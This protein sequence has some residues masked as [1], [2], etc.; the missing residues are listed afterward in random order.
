MITVGVDGCPAGWFAVRQSRETLSATLY[1]AFSSLCEDNLDATILVDIPM[2]LLDNQ[3][4]NVEPAARKLLG[5]RRSS[6]FPVPCRDAVYASSYR[7]ACLINL[8]QLGKKISMQAWNI[9]PKIREADAVRRRH[10]VEVYE[11]HP[12][13]DFAL[14]G[15]TPMMNGKKTPEGIN[16]RLALLE[17]ILPGAP[18]LFHESVARYPRSR[19]ARDDIVDAMAL[20][21]TAA[22]CNSGLVNSGLVEVAQHDRFGLAVQLII[23]CDG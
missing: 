23:P 7:E 11:S 1:T 6:V 8:Q 20:V 18:Q 2:G 14:L 22:T 13:L 4:R 12:E 3:E 16:E 19:L 15:D 10:P 17:S 21:A 5:S 9:C